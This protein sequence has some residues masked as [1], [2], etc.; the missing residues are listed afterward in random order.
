MLDEHESG[1]SVKEKFEAAN[2]LLFL[3]GA[4]EIGAAIG[5]NARQAHYLLSNGDIRC[6]HKVRGRWVANA[7]VLRREFGA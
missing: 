6:A 1:L 2:E 4:R 3:W 5:R 7:A